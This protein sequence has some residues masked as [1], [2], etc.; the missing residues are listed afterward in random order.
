VLLVTGAYYPEISA[1]GVQCRAVAAA[2][3]GRVLFSVLTTGV[4]PSLPAA[5]TVDDVIVHRVTIDVGSRVSKT[6]AAV[7]LVARG[8]RAVR[9]CDVVHLHGFSRKNV[10]MTVLARLL[11][12]PLVLTLHT[13]G[14]DEPQ[15]VRRRGRLAYWAFRS[16]DLVLSVSPYLSARYREVDPVGER[17]R[18]T[19]NGVDTNRF[20]PAS[21]DEA[22]ALRRTLGWP[23][24]EPIVLFVGFFSRDKRP[25]LLFRAWR[26]LATSGIRARLVYVGA[27]SAGYYEID[28]SLAR[29]I[30]ADAAELGHDNLVMFVE[31]TNE[32]ERLFRAADVFVLPSAREAHPLALLEAMACGLPSIATRLPGATDVLIED[33]VNGLLVPLDDEQ[34]LANA[35][36]SML[37]DR[38]AA[39]LMGARARETAT[40]QY[41]IRR[42]AEEWAAA[43]NTVLTS[44]R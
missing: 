2:L 32:I 38:P 17:V 15:V 35:M 6:S 43:Y 21:R 12:K 5:D 28:R 9:S 11:G 27:K 4:D 23:E 16:P 19:P 8:L 25:D 26:R 18:L 34:A 13:A 30:R 20:R 37:I 36:L 33:G 31:P 40:T 14:Q 41:D 1:A 7:R 29:Q 39:R 3:R 22:V 42:T 44:H 24:T 10:P